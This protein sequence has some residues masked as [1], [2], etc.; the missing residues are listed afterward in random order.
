M[1][2]GRAACS[3]LLL[4]AL[5][6]CGEHHAAGPHADG[7][8]AEWYEPAPPARVVGPLYS[9][10]TRDLAVYLLT[11][12]A[13]HILIGGAMP[14]SEALIQAAIREAGFDPADIRILLDT[15]AHADHAGTLAAFQQLTGA[16]VA[17]SEGDRAL[18]ESGGTT[19]YLFADVPSLHFPPVHVDRVLADGD[20]VSLG[21]VTLTARLTPGHTPGNTTWITDVEQDGRTWR[22]VLAGSCSVNPGTRLTHEPSYPGILED[23]RRSLA[24][25]ESLQPDIW[26]A[27]HASQCGLEAKRARAAGEGAAAFV[28]P[29]GYRR[30]VAEWR[31]GLEQAVAAE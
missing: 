20:Q 12:P 13:G 14:G 26:V 2:L 8:P 24:L 15:H 31:A 28:D 25:L 5:A 3:A 11:T 9:V 19:D 18:L 27:P 10:G 29:E 21:G 23:Y 6:A 7:F 4:A 16:L 17:A 30:K 1:R 22:V